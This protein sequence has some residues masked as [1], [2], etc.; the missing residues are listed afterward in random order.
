MRRKS[1]FAFD[2]IWLDLFLE[3]DLTTVVNPH[4]DSS[5]CNH[6]I[7]LF[8][9]LEKQKF[10]FRRI[11][12]SLGSNFKLLNVLGSSLIL[13]MSNFE[14]RTF[15]VAFCRQAQWKKSKQMF[16]IRHVQNDELLRTQTYV[17]GVSSGDLVNVEICI[18]RVN[19]QSSESTKL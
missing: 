9:G 1:I 10:I 3:I 19:I 18:F 11:F 13:D 7:S 8:R 4:L 14:Y 16:K 17:V 12:A 2:I 5:L 15:I 6:F